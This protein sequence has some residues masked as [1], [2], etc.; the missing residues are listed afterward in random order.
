MLNAARRLFYIFFSFGCFCHVPKN[1]IEAYLHNLHRKCRPGAR[2]FMMI[3]DFD[4]YNR[5]IDNL[6]IFEAERACHGRRYRPARWLWKLIESVSKPDN[7]R[8][9]VKSPLRED[10][11]AITWHHL[12][13]AGA[14][15]MLENAGYRVIDPDMG[16]NHRDPV[17]H[18]VRP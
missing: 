4:K 9:I 2:G 17:I 8:P 15:A 11:G 14:C 18:F 10:P 1:G 6:R 13:T 5:A 12:S 3:G 16:V 7:L